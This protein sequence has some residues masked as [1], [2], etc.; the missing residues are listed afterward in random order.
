MQWD[1]EEDNNLC[2][3]T[4]RSL[5]FFFGLKISICP[6]AIGPFPQDKFSCSDN[7]TRIFIQ[8]FSSGKYLLTIIELPL[9]PNFKLSRLLLL[10]FMLL[11]L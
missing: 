9:L 6:F 3:S 5:F 8:M 7:L 11:T 4:S 10:K 2:P 1:D